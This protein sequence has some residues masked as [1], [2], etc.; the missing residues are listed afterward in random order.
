M[1]ERI[2][3]KAQIN[4]V[5]NFA[6]Q[7]N[8]V[9]VVRNLILK[10]KTEENMEHIKVKITFDPAFARDY[11]YEIQELLPEASVEIRPVKIQVSSEYLFSLTEK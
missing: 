10:N 1:N 4:K 7:Q 6:M 9:P 2:E 5:I 3:V 8:Y 11:E